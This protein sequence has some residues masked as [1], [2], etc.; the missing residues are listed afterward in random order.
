[1]KVRELK[2]KWRKDIEKDTIREEQ[3]DE[4]RLNEKCPYQSQQVAVDYERDKVYE[5][6]VV[7]DL[8]DKPCLL[9]SGMECEV[10]DEIRLEEK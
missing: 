8:V 1:M 2:L 3:M 10:W 4:D 9:E 6:A 5:G 7:C